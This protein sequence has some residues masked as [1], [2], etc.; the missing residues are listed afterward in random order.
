MPKY[1]IIGNSAGGIGAA[2]AIRELDTGGSIAIVSDEPFPAYSRPLISEYLAGKTS[3]EKMLYRPEDF[4]SRSSIEAHLGKRVTGIDL[5]R[6]YVELNDGRHLEFEKL[7]LATG[8][9]P[10][11]PPID[12][13]WRLGVFTFTTLGDAQRIE[14]YLPGVG[15]AV[16][17]G[18]G[19]IG[20]SV[21]EALVHRGVAVTV[22][23]LKDRILNVL[24]D[25]R[26]SAIAQSAV[27]DAGVRVIVN[28][29]VMSIL[30]RSGEDDAVG[31]VLLNSGEMIECDMVIVAIGVIPRTD[32]VAGTGI[33]VN[34]GILVDRFMQTSEPGVY[35]C[36]DVSEA[37]DFVFD[38]NR[39][40]PIWPTAY[41]GGRVA[42][43][44]MAGVPTE[45]TGGTSMNSLKYFGLSIV[46]A[47]L[48]GGLENS[49]GHEI[50]VGGRPDGG[51]YRKIVVRDNRIVGMTF[52]DDIERSGIILGLM[53]DKS[54]VATL[55]DVLVGDDF[56]F[57]LLPREMR[58]A[59]FGLGDG[60]RP[61]LEAEGP[62]AED[63]GDE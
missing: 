9:V 49:N 12:G 6:H 26:A 60:Y 11:I 59:R 27:V 1:L 28:A 24:L 37:Y 47:G 29:T 55:K 22:V 44:N 21:A 42:G 16:V 35:A 7:L 58:Q 4:Y 45:Y 48:V 14:R 61:A 63:V 52:V 13:K 51:P 50:V 17:I 32:L 43:R 25:E 46:S 30:G 19:L 56:G 15:R 18:G 2:E 62:L 10:F 31:R 8:G 57:A 38:E 5:G 34:R 41:I 33:K 39:V 36:G 3:I 54:N 53:R 40:V 20:I 23:E